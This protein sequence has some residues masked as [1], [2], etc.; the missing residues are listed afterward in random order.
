MSNK[1]Q[2]KG[3]ESQVKSQKLANKAAHGGNDN[4]EEGSRYFRG[5][6]PAP[7]PVSAYPR[8]AA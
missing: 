6:G 1:S 7:D 3:K 2:S 5:S 8:R 4:R